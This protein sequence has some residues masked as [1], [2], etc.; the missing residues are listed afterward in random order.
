[1]FQK[2]HDTD[3]QWKN[4][5]YTKDI[6][7]KIFWKIEYFSRYF[8]SNFEILEKLWRT[9]IIFMYVPKKYY[10]NTNTKNYKSTYNNNIVLIVPT[11]N[12][13]KVHNSTNREK[14]RINIQYFVQYKYTLVVLFAFE[15]LCFLFK[16]WESFIWSSAV[17]VTLIQCFCQSCGTMKQKKPRRGICFHTSSKP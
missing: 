5:V 13:K 12:I 17:A 1:M 8:G 3:R 2:Y 15:K 10:N 7:Q 11:Q 14:R 6:F 9:Q 4:I 16:F